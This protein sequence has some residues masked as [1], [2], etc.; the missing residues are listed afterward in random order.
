MHA[1]LTPGGL[2]SF[3]LAGPLRDACRESTQ[4]SARAA[5]AYSKTRGKG[6]G[7]MGRYFFLLLCLAAGSAAAATVSL[8]TLPAEKA[9]TV[10]AGI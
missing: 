3:S 10:V 1:A 4:A 9:G 2:V 5:S 8:K 7:A 6:S